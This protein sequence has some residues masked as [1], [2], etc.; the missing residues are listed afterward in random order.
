MKSKRRCMYRNIRNMFQRV[1]WALR[2]AVACVDAQRIARKSRYV[3]HIRIFVR[4]PFTYFS[5]HIRPLKYD[6]A[7]MTH[8]LYL[9]NK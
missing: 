6:H 4:H 7:F 2:Q 8:P 9:C 3:G 1:A 5:V